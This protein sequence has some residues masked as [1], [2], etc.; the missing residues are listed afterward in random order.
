MSVLN[1]RTVVSVAND[2]RYSLAVTDRVL[3]TV[4]ILVRVVIVVPAVLIAIVG[5]IGVRAVIQFV[6]DSAGDRNEPDD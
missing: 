2:F 5:L 4:R 1:P 6:V 3:V